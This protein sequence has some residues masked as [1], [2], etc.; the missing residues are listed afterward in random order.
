[1]DSFF[2]FGG[3]GRKKRRVTV[4]VGFNLII[5]HFPHFSSSQL[6]PFFP[7]LVPPP[8]VCL[9]LFIFFLY[10]TSNARVSHEKKPPLLRV[11]IKMSNLTNFRESLS[12]FSLP[13]PPGFIYFF[14]IISEKEFNL[15]FSLYSQP[16]S[17]ST[18]RNEKFE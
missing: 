7:C 13:P 11:L 12:P 14:F 16:K 15:I 18:F 8:P 6:S 9:F 1:M 10:P 17:K 2:F 4:A 3:G 5:S